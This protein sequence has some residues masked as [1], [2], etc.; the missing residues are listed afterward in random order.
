MGELN[1]C[2]LPSLTGAIL[3][4]AFEIR[5]PWFVSHCTERHPGEVE[6]VVGVAND[7]SQQRRSRQASPAGTGAM[8][9]NREYHSAQRVRS[10]L[11]D[12]LI[13]I[14]QP[15]HQEWNCRL[16]GSP[17]TMKYICQPPVGHTNS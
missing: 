14:A 6:V 9:T 4:Q 12:L 17:A 1:L 10:L 16:T 7:V 3:S 11:P 13:R 8:V 2:T 15:S 5:P